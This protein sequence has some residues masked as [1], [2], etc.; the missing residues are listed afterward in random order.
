MRQLLPPR[1]AP[2]A[3]NVGSWA[4]FAIPGF[5]I[6]RFISPGMALRLPSR[7]SSAP[8]ELPHFK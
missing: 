2:T 5:F 8:G 3:I 4:T 1:C 7:H 6:S